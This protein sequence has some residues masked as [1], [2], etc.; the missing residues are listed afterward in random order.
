[1][2][3]LTSELIS[4][5]LYTGGIVSR[6]FETPTGAQVSDGL[7][8]LNQVI[9]DRTVDEG[10]IP[11]TGR[12]T[13][14]A[15]SGTASYNIPNLIDIE[16]FTFFIDSVRYQTKNQGRQDFFGT[17][18]ATNINSLPFNW[19]IERNLAGATLYLYFVPDQ[20]YPLEIWGSFRL[21]AV[22][23]FQDLSL[24]LDAFYTNFLEYLLSERLCQFYSYVVPVNVSEQLKKYYKWISNQTNVMDLRMQKLST[25]SGNAAI[26]YAVVNLAGSGFLPVN[27]G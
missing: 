1:M 25:L 19:H 4:R 21:S 10:T 17:F 9:A 8:L 13:F 14:N 7:M 18:R 5:A 27:I 15:V 2:A 6:D 24:T 12:Y 16:T 26:N 11:Y 22:T 3:L 20:N 23:M